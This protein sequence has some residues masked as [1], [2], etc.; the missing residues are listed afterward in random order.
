MT[1]PHAFDDIQK[2]FAALGVR[3]FA[4]ALPEGR[5]Q[6]LNAEG[7]V[8]AHARCV[9]VLSFASAN[10]SM[11]WAEELPHFKEAG[12]PTLERPDGMPGYQINI[13]ETVAEQMAARV[14]RNAG[15]QFLYPAKYG[16][17]SVLYLSITEFAAVVSPTAA[18]EA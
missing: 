6:W 16:N 9:A 12:V 10:E 17:G 11:A 15:A 2:T 4:A 1:D 8:V 18:G 7:A 14:A 5:I 3:D 13:T